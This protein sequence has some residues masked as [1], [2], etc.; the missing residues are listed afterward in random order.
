MSKCGVSNQ[1]NI[2]IRKFLLPSFFTISMK[3]IHKHSVPTMLH[4]LVFPL[5]KH[6]NRYNNQVNSLPIFISKQRQRHHSLTKTHLISEN[7][8]SD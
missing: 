6:S 1:Y 4:N 2:I 8:T 3:L 5:K 7:S